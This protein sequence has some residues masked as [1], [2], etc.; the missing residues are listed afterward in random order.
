MSGIYSH[1]CRERLDLLRTKRVLDLIG[2]NRLVITHADPRLECVPLA[3]L[4]KFVGQTLQTAALRE[5]L[6]ALSRTPPPATDRL[7]E[8]KTP[9]V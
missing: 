5:E 8:Q 7:E 4:Y 6:S 3:T 1:F 2:G 9:R